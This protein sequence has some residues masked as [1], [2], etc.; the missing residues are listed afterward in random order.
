MKHK[1][2]YAAGMTSCCLSQRLILCIAI[3]AFG[4]TAKMLTAVQPLQKE[5]LSAIQ[6]DM[7]STMQSVKPAKDK[8]PPNNLVL[9]GE[10]FVLWGDLFGDGHL[11]AIAQT[12]HAVYGLAYLEWKSGQWQFREAWQ[13]TADWV[14]EGVKPSER[15]Y[16][17]ITPP[18]VP[19]TLKDLNGDGIPEVLVSF[20]NDGYKLGY[21]IIQADSKAS[22]LKLLDVYSG[23]GEPEYSDGYLIGFD[24]SGRKAWWGQNIYYKW[25]DGHP[26]KYATW[27]DGNVEESDM[28]PTEFTV[29]TTKESSRGVQSYRVLRDED[30]E[31]NKFSDDLCKAV[32]AFRNGKRGTVILKEE[33]PFAVLNFKWKKNGLEHKEANGQAAAE[34]LYFFETLTGLPWKAYG[35]TINGEKIETAKERQSLLEVDVFGSPEA[36]KL[37]SKLDGRSKKK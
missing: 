34:E 13:A 25:I 9:P 8:N 19:F 12:K 20:N 1:E 6:S 36:I 14:P 31:F 22:C 10:R 2:I 7:E 26:T 33:K 11:W 23:S 37:L 16:F 15:D 24:A 21:E 27:T 18:L 35:K 5:E 32:K 30:D 29:E 17:H 28:G 4:I 3:L